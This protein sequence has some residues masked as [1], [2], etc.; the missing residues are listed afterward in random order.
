MKIILF[1]GIFLHTL[2]LFAAE[3]AVPKLELM[4]W[5]K[6][7]EG[8][9]GVFSRG[10]AEITLQSK[11][12]TFGGK[13]ELLFSDSDLEASSTLPPTYDTSA[14]EQ[15]FQKTLGL[16]SLSVELKRLFQ[17]P[18]SLAY[19][20]GTTDTLGSG[21]VFSQYFGTH[22]ISTPVRG[23]VYFFQGILY[24]GMHTIGGTGIKVYTDKA[25]DK[26]WFSAYTYQDQYL[27]KGKYSSDFWFAA[28]L[29]TL[30]IETILGVTYP[31]STY[32]IYRG[33]ILFHYITPEGGEFF[34]QIGIP[35]W[36]PKIDKTF[37]ADLFYFLFEPRVQLGL[38]GVSLTFFWHPAYY[39]QTPT[40]EEGITDL[41]FRLSYGK[42]PA[43][44][45]KLGIE[46][47]LRL[48]TREGE[49]ISY[50]ITPFY[51]LQA[52]GIEWEFRLNFNLYPYKL[53]TLVEGFVGAKTSF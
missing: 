5:G 27:G 22:P 42:L 39:E 43:T 2:F 23:Y 8:T 32:G 26:F 41:Y 25:F 34:T 31:S 46:N 15:A 45:W 52:T 37:T 11:E 7:D 4:S 47:G 14:L 19:F 48:N 21:D 36:D 3:V 44:R 38:F 1:L 10:Y 17:L 18:I 28:N 49:Q 35:R 33:G 20:T 30:K 9:F 24:E 13:I 16:K 40:E 51:N 53:N 12:E 29:D 50:R 6:W